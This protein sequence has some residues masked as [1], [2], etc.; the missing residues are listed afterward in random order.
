MADA[1]VI[2]AI[3][4]FKSGLL[5]DERALQKEMVRRWVEVERSLEGQIDA[6]AQEIDGLHRAGKVVN[7]GKLYRLERWRRLMAQAQEQVGMYARYADG[8]ITQRQES[9]AYLGAEHAVTAIGLTAETVGVT[10]ARMS[11]AAVEAMVGAIAGTAGDGGPLGKLLKLRMVRDGGKPLP[12]AYERLT[13]TLVD[14]AA[15]GWNPRKTARLMQNDLSEGLNKALQIA[16]TESMRAYRTTQVTQYRESGVVRGIK[17]VCAHDDRVCAACLAD[18]GTI[19]PLDAQIPDHVQGRCLVGGTLVA[20]PGVRAFVSRRYVGDVVTVR[21]AAGKLLT[22]TPNH[23]ILTDRGWVAANLIH[24]GD[25]VVSGSFGEWAP[26]GMGPD[27]YQVPIRV[28]EIPRALRMDGLRRVPCAAEDFHGDGAGSEVYVV[29]ANRLLRDGGQPA[30]G[31]PLSE[32][33]LGWRC[34]RASSFPG[35]RDLHPMLQ[36]LLAPATRLLSD[37]DA[38]MVFL[39]RSLS[40]QQSVRFCAATSGY[41]G[42]SQFTRD[43]T[44]IHAVRLCES[45]LGLSGLVAAGNLLT[46]ERGLRQQSGREVLGGQPVAFGLGAEEPARLERIREAL[47]AGMEPG[48]A[49]FDALPGDIRLDCVLEIGVRRF[50]GH[51]YNLQTSAGWYSASD[52]VTHNCGQAPIVTGAQIPTWTA[53]EDWLRTQNED[54]QRTILGP[55]RWDLW[56]KG[57][58]QFSELVTHKTHETWGSSVQPTPLKNLRG[59]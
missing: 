42:H 14:A 53:G 15:Q 21:T 3:R 41:A 18:E 4:D 27:E 22:V 23:P 56:R 54:V 26:A 43:A 39:Y 37:L 33:G 44:A 45:V 20:G 19:Y 58:V 52:I 49:G 46:R 32:Q 9:L 59:D 47:R 36:R 51:V 11:P 50:A 31:Q 30:F 7:P 29:R 16:R 48:A 1:A 35:A 5:A 38:A 25:H 10:F 40:G 57:E 17:R 12:G 2:L 34:I 13:R 24:E 28:E 6:L 55:G 8:A